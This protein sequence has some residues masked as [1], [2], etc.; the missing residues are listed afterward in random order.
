MYDIGVFIYIRVIFSDMRACFTS[1]QNLVV[2]LR[3]VI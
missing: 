1:F 2:R 3:K